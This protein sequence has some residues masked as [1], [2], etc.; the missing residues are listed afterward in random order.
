MEV[1]L[2]VT[3]DAFVSSWTRGDDQQNEVSGQVRNVCAE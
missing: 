3:S 2:V 1:V